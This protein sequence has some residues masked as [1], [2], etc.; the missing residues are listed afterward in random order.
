MTALKIIM[1]T[2]LFRNIF[3]RQL[4]SLDLK[5]KQLENGSTVTRLTK[6]LVKYKTI[7]L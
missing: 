7:T 3:R 2:A 5:Q 1:Q 6:G 4:S